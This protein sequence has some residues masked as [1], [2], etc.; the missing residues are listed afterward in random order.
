MPAAEFQSLRVKV[1]ARF[2]ELSPQGALR[3]G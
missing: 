3:T 2:H 1:K